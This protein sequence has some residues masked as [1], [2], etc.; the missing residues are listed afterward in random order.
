MQV[1]SVTEDDEVT[2]GFRHKRPIMITQQAKYQITLFGLHSRISSKDYGVRN[3]S[4]P[5]KSVVTTQRY[6]V[7][8]TVPH[9]CNL[10]IRSQLQGVYV[11]E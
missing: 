11:R 6:R 1:P 9:M 4:S 7:D 10:N 3:L 5:Q 2:T 8:K